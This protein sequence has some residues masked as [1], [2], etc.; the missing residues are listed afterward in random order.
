M[1]VVIEPVKS[2]TAAPWPEVPLSSAT[3]RSTP[4]KVMMRF[5]KLRPPYDA[6]ESNGVSALSAKFRSNTVSVSVA[7][8]A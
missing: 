8:R 2:V 1:P 4:S 6:G 3:A 7:R 5:L